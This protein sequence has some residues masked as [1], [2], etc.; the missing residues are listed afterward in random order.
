LHP[1][2]FAQAAAIY[3]IIFSMT[4][5]TKLQVRRLVDV[6]ESSEVSAG[7]VAVEEREGSRGASPLSAA[8][9][10]GL[11]TSSPCRYAPSSPHLLR[12]RVEVGAG[13]W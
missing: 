7:E 10:T 8:S 1:C 13:V 12:V 9:E 5:M 11:A 3:E 4:L 2:T 6:K